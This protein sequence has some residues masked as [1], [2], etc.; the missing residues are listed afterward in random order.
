MPQITL[1]MDRDTLKKL[2]IAVQIENTSIS[3]WV[4]NKVVEALSKQTWP[5][6]YFSLFGSLA[7]S[8]LERP[9]Q[10]L[11]SKDAKRKRL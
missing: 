8:D 2:E 5:N 1:Y 4:K 10:P 11:L 9:Q 6:D 7:G 3:K